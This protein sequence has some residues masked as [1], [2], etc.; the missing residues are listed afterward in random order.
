MKKTIALGLAICFMST[1]AFAA[2]DFTDLKDDHWAYGVVN[3][4]VDKGTVKGYEDGS[5]KPDGT[6]TRA[7]FAKMMG[8]GTIKWDEPYSD[9][10]SGHW[11]YDY[12]MTS[13]IPAATENTF[14]PDTAILR[15]DAIYALW[16]RYG[17]KTVKDMPGFVTKQGSAAA[18]AYSY[19]IMTGDDGIDLRLSD[20]ITRA[21]A[22]ALI[23]RADKSQTNMGFAAAMPESTA[24]IVFESTG[25]FASEYSNEANITYGEFAR[26]VV[27]LCH[28]QVNPDYTNLAAEKLYESEYARD[29]YVIG[30]YALGKDIVNADKEKELVTRADAKE[31]FEKIV[32]VMRTGKQTDFSLCLYEET[33]F[34]KTITHKEIAAML[35]QLDEIIGLENS[36]TALGTDDETYA[37]TNEKIK[38]SSLPASAGSYK[39]ILND[40]PESVY[41]IDLSSAKTLPKDQYYFSQMFAPLFLKQCDKLVSAAKTEYG[42]DIKLVYY[43]TLCF[44][45]GS[46]FTMIL[47]AEI[48]SGTKTA[49]E[50][51]GSVLIPNTIDGNTFFVKINTNG[52]SINE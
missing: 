13:E 25:A 3:T 51:F 15:D 11:A 29:M 35:V 8:T 48:L 21:E 49:Q 20:T 23:V 36:Y 7:E 42:T 34:S 16:E 5:F 50:L 45:N 14:E 27:Q 12:V 19:G 37:R 46:G 33:D 2:V 9:V 28:S 38:K 30:N 24:K 1:N 6:V 41:A 43:P 39:A 22:A 10:P 52:Y 26:A 17:S 47:K 18:W 31:C 44:D 40:I 4:L 32:A